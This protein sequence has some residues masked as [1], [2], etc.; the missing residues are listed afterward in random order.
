MICYR[1]GDASHKVSKCKLEKG[2]ICADN[3]MTRNKK[4]IKKGN[5]GTKHIWYL[6]G[7][8]PR[9]MTWSKSLLEDIVKKDGPTITY[10]HNG[11][12]ATKGFGTIKGNSILL[13]N[14]SYVKGIQHNLI[15]INQLCHADYE[16]YFNKKE[17]KVINQKNKGHAADDIISLIKQWE[18]LY[19]HK[20]KQLHSDHGTNLSWAMVVEVGLPLS[21][22]D[23]A[24]NITCYTQNR[25]IIVKCHGKTTY[26]LLKGRKPD[27][28]YFHV[29]GCVCYN[30]NQRDQHSN[31]EAKFD[32][33]F[34]GYSSVSKGFKVFNLLKK[35]IEETT[36]FTFIEDSFIHDRI[37]HPSS[38][39]SELT[40]S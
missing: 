12:G 21:F 11:K 14:M 29:F 16:V 10:G 5:L 7:R 15:S 9:H 30:L 37:D 24:V 4:W 6:D 25:S 20:V 28:S 22:W 2:C 35:T 34:L 39:L 18:V 13:K 38:I 23:E 19:D 36:R 32:G 3:I 26:E 33:V 27:I 17:G 8:F 31:F 1:C 40:S